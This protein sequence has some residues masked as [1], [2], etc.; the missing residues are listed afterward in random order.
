MGAAA[1]APGEG[2]VAPVEAGEH[3]ERQEAIVYGERALQQ[4]VPGLEYGG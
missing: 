2:R 1:D 4:S 3:L